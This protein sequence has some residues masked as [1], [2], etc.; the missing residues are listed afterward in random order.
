MEDARKDLTFAENAFTN[1]QTECG[2]FDFENE[3]RTLITE[4]ETLESQTAADQT[5]LEEL[6][7]KAKALEALVAS[8]P[9]TIEQRT[10]TNPQPN[11]K[12]TLLEQRIYTLEDALAAN[13][14]RLDGTSQSRDLERQRL[15][16]LIDS[17]TR[18]LQEQPEFVDAGPSTQ[19][20]PNPEHALRKQQLDDLRLELTA[21]EAAAAIRSGQLVD[22]K[23]RLMTMAQCGPTFQS[24]ESRTLEARHRFEGFQTQHE[25]ASLMGSMDQQM[26]NLRR[27]QEATLPNEKEGPLRGKLVML[28]LLLG[29][30]AGCGLAFLRNIFDHR[31]H[32]AFEVEHFLGT[33]VL[34]VIPETRTSPHGNHDARR[35][36][37]AT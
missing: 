37:S 30:V 11:P 26:S 24:L 9:E 33:S 21:L 27:I 15:T 31:L 13:E 25:R 36:L 1:F 18:S 17:T 28:G 32:D 5:H 19:R 6:R 10:L 4:K 14:R 12:R 20:L 23:K 34:A 7:D 2:V 29:G 8:L 22:H 3:Q 16:Q 35:R